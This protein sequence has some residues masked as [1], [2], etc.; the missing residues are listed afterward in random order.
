MNDY[1]AYLLSLIS[2]TSIVLS[3]LPLLV[4]I[5]RQL[6][7][8]HRF[9]LFAIYWTVAG[10]LTVI[11]EYAL[12][13]SPAMNWINRIYNIVDSSYLL[14]LIYF[15][16]SHA[17]VKE[18]LKWVI[19]ILSATF[20]VISVVS[21]LR[22]PWET[23]IVGLGVGFVLFYIV[24]ELI[25]YLRRI[26]TTPFEKTMQFIFTALLFEYGMSV[27]IYVFGYLVSAP[28]DYIEGS[29]FLYH[30]S[31]FISITLACVGLWIY[32]EKKKKFIR[33]DNSGEIVY[34]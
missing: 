10:V 11:E 31:A 27:I 21:G 14:T 8:K 30:S 19:P 1:F 22:D 23:L 5:I 29:L 17:K 18:S 12:V 7:K 20:L 26:E 3:F 34:I 4:V 13:P 2:G 15:T 9:Y 32:K 16:T 28:E 24:W 6:W 33:N 25:Q